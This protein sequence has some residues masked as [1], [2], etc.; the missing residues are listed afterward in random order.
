[1]SLIYLKKKKE[2]LNKYMSKVITIDGKTFPGYIEGEP[3]G[4]KYSEKKID[5]YYYII[6][7]EDYEN[8]QKGSE[9]LYYF[10]ED[11]INSGKV[12]KFI[13][14]NIFIIKN[15]IKMSIWSLKFDDIDLYIKDYT[16]VRKENQLKENLFELY[17]AGYIKILDEPKEK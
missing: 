7:P 12:L 11:K 16:I 17:N 5:E 15:D 9:I 8:I 10:D 14:P 6:E 4:Y 13:K 3:T 2:I 1:M